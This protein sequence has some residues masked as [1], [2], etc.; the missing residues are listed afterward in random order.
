MKGYEI[1]K[2]VLWVSLM[3]AAYYGIMELYY[4]YFICEN[5]ARFGFL[6]NVNPAKYVETKIL[7]LLVLG[8]SIYVSNVSSFIYSVFIFF[9]IFFLVP[10]LVLFSF[11]DKER[12]PLYA[13][14]ILLFSLAAISSSRI[15]I[16]HIRSKALSSGVVM[17]F[18]LLCLAP[19]IWN[20]GLYLNPRNLILDDVY[21]TRDI[22]DE[23]ATSGINYLFN[24]L[25]KAIV[26][27]C[28]VF[29][30]I[31]KRY[32]FAL[33]TFLALLYLYAISGNKL[34]YI[35]S[36]MILFFF[37]LGRDYIQK[38]TI[39]SVCI[40]LGLLA[41]P[42]IDHYF[43]HNDTLKGAFVMRMLFL[44]SNM[45][46]LYIDFF[47]DGPLYF[48]ESHLFSM[49][50]DYPYSKP[51]GYVIAERYFHVTDMNANNGFIGDGFM[52]LGFTGIGLNIL[53]VSLIFLY[54][55]SLNLDSRYLG[56]FFVMVF[57]FLSLPFLTMF[58]TSGLWI[59]FL[60]ALTFMRA[61]TR[62]ADSEQST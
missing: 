38:T 48:A 34:V 42:L 57:L 46:Y 1:K 18:V 22:F 9:S 39:I 26:P 24:W 41:A 59:I 29:F 6:I 23:S 13:I 11:S 43:F 12:L 61:D 10:T 54:F 35:T 14:V 21:S 2:N 37:F 58:N 25:I 45:N 15:K 56:I 62:L 60:F 5:Y 51:I 3:M 32:T 40:V 52:N 28:L 27:I 16:P 55:N 4:Y 31:H 17:M 50:F 20:F 49:F 47:R 53:V 30:L 7:F 44:P 36:F 19:I 33:V 8:I